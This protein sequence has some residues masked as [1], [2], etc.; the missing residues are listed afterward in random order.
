[1]LAG[2]PADGSAAALDRAERELGRDADDSGT[3]ALRARIEE[4]ARGLFDH[5]RMQLSV[6]KY[7][8]IGVERGA[9]LDTLDTPL[10]DREWLAARFSRI[11][12]MDRED[13]R[14]AAISEIVHWTDPGAGGF[15]DDL[16]D[17]ERE[18][19]LRRAPGVPGDP[20]RFERGATGFGS[21]RAWRRSWITHAE[22]FYDDPLEL[23]YD[24]LDPGARYVV[25]V[26]YAGD[27]DENTPLRLVANGTIEVHG[28]RQKPAVPERQ[29]FAVPLEATRAGRLTLTWQPRQ[30][31]GGAGRGTQ[32]AEVWLVKAASE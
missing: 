25:R 29:E 14:L 17:P 10:D 2:A 16:G 23:A 27:L 21:G 4:L 7:G 19:H 13:A 8:A 31:T 30:G 20:S 22:S 24:G 1:V 18:P 15:Y 28:W 26:V 3:R 6:A 9:T 5:V 32:V 12:A 11:R